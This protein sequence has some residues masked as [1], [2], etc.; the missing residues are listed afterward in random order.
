MWIKLSV[1]DGKG[2]FGTASLYVFN[3]APC[4]LAKQFQLHALCSRKKDGVIRA[5]QEMKFI[6]QNLWSSHKHP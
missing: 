6:E 3:S 4:I 5:P 2:V 1:S